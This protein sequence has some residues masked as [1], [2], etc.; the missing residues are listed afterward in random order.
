MPSRLRYIVECFRILRLKKCKSTCCE[1][2]FEASSPPNTPTI[3]NEE[4]DNISKNN[5]LTLV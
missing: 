3:K 4:N 1:V 5:V 2:D